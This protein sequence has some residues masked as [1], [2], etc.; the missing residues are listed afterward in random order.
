MAPR[1]VVADEHRPAPITVRL[2]R[3]RVLAPVDQLVGEPGARL[4]EPF[5]LVLLAPQLLIGQPLAQLPGIRRVA[6]GDSAVDVDHVARPAPIVAR[7]QLVEL[8]RLALRRRGHPYLPPAGDRGV[9]R[10]PD[11]PRIAVQ[12]ELIQI[13]VSR[14]PPRGVGVGG[15][16]RH[17]VAGARVPFVRAEDLVIDLDIV[18]HRLERETVGARMGLDAGA[19]RFARLAVAAGQDQPG[20]GAPAH[21]RGH[22]GVHDLERGG[23]GLADLARP[24]SD[25]EA[26]RV[27][28]PALLVGIKGHGRGGIAFAHWSK[29][30]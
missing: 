1:D 13:H 10:A 15:E 23:E 26:G 9:E 6:L 25:L 2:S 3:A 16:R 24:Q 19:H 11:L 30:P 5:A 28:E 27:A 20:R 14:V 22:D 18:L 21:A 7:H 29:I 8:P 4:I 17:D 12:R